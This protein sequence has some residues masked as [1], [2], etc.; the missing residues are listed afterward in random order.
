RCPAMTVA[1]QEPADTLAS[2]RTHPPDV[3]VPSS[4]AWRRLA[5]VDDTVYPAA[6]TS[7]ARS[8]LVVAAPRTLAQ[9]LG[10]PGRDRPGSELAHK[11]PARQIPRFSMADPLRST[12]GLLAVIGVEVAATRADGNAGAATMRALTFRSRLTD[13]KADPVR[14]LSKV[15]GMPDP[16]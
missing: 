15:V 2:I 10:W 4:T 3:W 1:A 6:G 11:P 7:L 9:S 8:P 14:L 16:S 5:N 12:S 13:A